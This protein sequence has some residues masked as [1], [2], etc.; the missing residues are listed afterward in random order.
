MKTWLAPW[1]MAIF[2]RRS[3]L[4]LALA[5]LASGTALA[6][7]CWPGCDFGADENAEFA[8]H[9]LASFITGLGA[10][11]WVAYVMSLNEQLSPA[12]VQ[13]VPR[14]RKSAIGVT[15]AFWLF[16]SAA[17]TTQL[18]L[19]GCRF[20]A[21]VPYVAAALAVAVS[22]A[23]FGALPVIVAVFVPMLAVWAPRF[24]FFSSSAPTWMEIMLDV[25][26]VAAGAG[27][28]VLQL[29]GRG[30]SRLAPYERTRSARLMARDPRLRSPWAVA[31]RPTWFAWAFDRVLG[32][33]SPSARAVHG[34]S[35][36]FHWSEAVLGTLIFAFSGSVGACL[37]VGM[38]FLATK[39]RSFDLNLLLGQISIGTFGF[40]AFLAGRLLRELG[41]RQKEQALI[42]MLPG[43][44]NGQ[45]ASRWIMRALLMQHATVA[46]AA[47]VLLG[48]EML[49]VFFMFGIGPSGTFPMVATS[50]AIALL[51]TPALV[52]NFAT[53]RV[54]VRW[55]LLLLVPAFFVMQVLLSIGRI[56]GTSVVLAAMLVAAVVSATRYL[57]FR[58]AAPPL[59]VG[60]LAE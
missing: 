58:A 13:L 33:R 4:Y 30:E 10:T 18:C 6:A 60:R 29:G 47:L 32:I 17:L 41:S 1:I 5:W 39:S 21:L 2:G 50:L 25:S 16:M 37:V 38:T 8:V 49:V 26:T 7:Y 51:S 28:I 31:K 48:V 52:Q 9:M 15:I 54:S 44:P 46:A 43:V 11:L 53:M 45:A 55:W 40:S 56:N 59:P 57:L 42:L 12:A 27:W 24:G 3:A 22:G 20:M 23:S 14:L 19:V 34:M 36:G 35:P